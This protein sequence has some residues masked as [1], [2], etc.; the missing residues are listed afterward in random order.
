MKKQIDNISAAE[1]QEEVFREKADHYLIC[2]INGCP[3]REQCLRWLVGQYADPNLV[4]QTSVNPFNPKHGNEHCTMFRKKQ[5]VM[6]KRGFSNM[7]YDMPGHMEKS[8]RWALIGAFGHRQYFEMRKG[9]RLI[10]PDCQQRILETCRRFG[11]QGPI[12]YDGEQEEWD[13]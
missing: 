8:I 5:R 13:W 6:M 11:W 10:T 2:F 4:V 3:L 12:V 7:Y 1:Q 9:N